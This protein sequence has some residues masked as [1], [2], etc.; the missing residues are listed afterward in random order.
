MRLDTQAPRPERPPMDVVIW[1]GAALVVAVLIYYFGTERF[2]RNATQRWIDRM[3]ASPRLAACA[4]W[5]DRHHG[6]LRAAFH[7]VEFGGLTLVLV[8]VATL[9]SFRFDTPW[10]FLAWALACV[11]AYADEV[12]QARTPGRCFRRIDFLH[13]LLG[14]TLMLALLFVLDLLRG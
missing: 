7:Y 8:G 1:G 12:H 9:G 3:H 14:A 11:G 10:P 6:G 13:S 2:G 5:C 4:A